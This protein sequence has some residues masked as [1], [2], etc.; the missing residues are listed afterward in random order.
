MT[1]SI[2]NNL[3]IVFMILLVAMFACKSDVSGPDEFQEPVDDYP[4]PEGRIYLSHL[5][6]DPERVV[7][8][9]GLGNMNVL[10]EDHG[11]FF[12]PREGWYEEP[13]IPVYAPADGKITELIQDWYEW[14][15]PY[16][17]DLSITI[18]VSTTMTVSFGHMSDFAPVI[19]EAARELETGYA[20][21]NRVDIEVTAGQLLG[22]IGTQGAL[23]W[24][25]KDSDLELNFVNPERYP[26]PWI[27]SGC[28][29]DYY[30]EPLRSELFDITARTAEP[31]CGKIDYDVEGRIIGNWFWED[32][33]PEYAFEDY[34]THLAIAYDEYYGNKITISDGIAIRP[35][36]PHSGDE[37]TS[38]SQKFWVK[39]NA[40]RPEDIGI[41]QGMVK[42][43]IIKRP[44]GSYSPFGNLPVDPVVR[45]VVG[46]FL[47]EMLD[48]DRI[49][50]ERF[51]NKT[52]DEV[53]G[54]GSNAR[55][56]V[57]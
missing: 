36:S 14:L 54:F 15:D 24:H 56:Y 1:H 11:G 27:I 33:V 13:T 35:D 2:K 8:F 25:I 50:I 18:K 28:Y 40:P 38:A 3:V 55:I 44:Y 29:H 10:P 39:G 31:R 22:Y 4:Y 53:D 37:S 6:V 51:M 49:Q 32:E 52:A 42:Y 17:H 12:T 43:E 26:L 16:G 19:W 46:I 5:P 20:V 41:L 9:F 57:R 47:V 21:S 23:D 7:E 30:R 45:P 34:S 48:T